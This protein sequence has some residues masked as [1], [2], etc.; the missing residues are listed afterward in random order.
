MTHREDT[1]RRKERGNHVKVEEKVDNKSR[2]DAGVTKSR[3]G[4][5][6]FSHRDC[7]GRFVIKE[8]KSSSWYE[9]KI[10]RL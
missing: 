4:R 9:H 10:L 5:E 2:N 8:H 7:R 6:G 1:H 3:K